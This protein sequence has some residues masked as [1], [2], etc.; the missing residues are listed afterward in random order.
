MRI[1]FLKNEDRFNFFDD[2]RTSL[3]LKNWRELA[4]F[5]KT[6]RTI[7]DKYRLGEFLIPE[8]RFLKLLKVLDRD[9]QDDYLNKITKIEDNWGAILGGKKAYQLNKEA[10][11]E[12]RKRGGKGG[13]NYTPKFDINM[14]LS[15]ELC[16]FIGAFIGDG[17]TNKY[18][19]RYFVQITGDKVLDYEYHY[20]YLNLLCQ[21][22]FNSQPRIYVTENGLRFNIYSKTL[23]EMLTKRFQFPAGKKSYTVV[24][25]EE[26]YN[27]E[28]LKYT[29][30]G[31]FDTDGGIGVDKRKTYKIP[32]IRINYTSVSKKL[33]K[34]VNLSLLKLEIPH[35]IHKKGN[36]WMIQINGVRNV[37]RFLVQVGFSNKRHLE[38]VR[39]LI[40]VSS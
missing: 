25:P 29:L 11:E 17:F 22:T 2:T 14:S 38:K 13:A 1:K 33:I 4:S 9:K 12:G 8:D 28:F 7:S 18:Q 24:I 27:S 30:R 15:P 40:T 3:R 23:F 5:L 37:K 16:E 19:S 34:Q 32:Y 39:Y 35:S 26:I 6:H 10:F 36:S 31:M 21:K 20:N